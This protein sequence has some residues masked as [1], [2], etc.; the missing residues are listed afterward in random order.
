MSS[1]CAVR[2][3]RMPSALRCLHFD[4]LLHL[5]RSLTIRFG[6][7]SECLLRPRGIVGTHIEQ[8]RKNESRK[9]VSKVSILVVGLSIRCR[10]QLIAESRDF[11]EN[12]SARRK[13]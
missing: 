8:I 1:F 6:N 11:Q 12:Q 2:H 5:F 7:T 4:N 3:I 13:L 9:M 10:S